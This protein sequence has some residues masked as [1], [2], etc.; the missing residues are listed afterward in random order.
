MGDHVEEKGTTAVKIAKTMHCSY[1]AIF[2]L[3]VIKHA[4]ETT[5]V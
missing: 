4:Q 2:K 3:I 1:D 5:A